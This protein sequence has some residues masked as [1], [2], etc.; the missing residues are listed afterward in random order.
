M[1]ASIWDNSRAFT[2][3][4]LLS[5]MPNEFSI[6][7]DDFDVEIEYIIVAAPQKRKREQKQKKC[8][9][10][11]ITNSEHYSVAFA[12][13]QSRERGRGVQE[14]NEYREKVTWSR[15]KTENF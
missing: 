8:G 12:Q 5:Q 13:P 1:Y 3:Y 9:R 2:L 15:K 4:A 7:R 14:W 10:D 6:N 11:W